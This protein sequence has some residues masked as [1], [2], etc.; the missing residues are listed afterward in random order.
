MIAFFK[1]LIPLILLG[2]LVFP[3]VTIFW[4][5]FRKNDSLA[6]PSS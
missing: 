4:Y 2:N 6:V 5:G 3:L 1:A